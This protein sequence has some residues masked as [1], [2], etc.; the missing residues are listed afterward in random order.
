MIEV[1]KCIRPGDL[2][3]IENAKEAL[4]NK[5]FSHR[6][7][8]L[9]KVGRYKINQRLGLKTPNKLENHVLNIDDFV[10]IVR[11]V[12]RLNNT[13]DAVGD[14]ID[15]LCNRRLKLVGE[16]IQRSFRIGLLR[17]ERNIKERMLRLD[18]ETMM[19]QQ[20]IN[21]RPVVAAVKTFF[22][23]SQLSQYMDQV[24][25]LSELAHKRRL[26]AMGPG[27]LKREYAKFA[28]RDSH[29]THYG[30]IC[31]VETS[32]GANIGLILNLALYA[33]INEY[34]FL[35][36]PYCKVLSKGK[37]AEIV[38]EVA[39][40]NLLDN[41]GAVIVKA[42][43]AISK[44]SAERLAKVDAGQ[45]WQLQPR[46]LKDKVVYLDTKQE[47]EAIILG[48]SAQL[49]E[50]GR[51]IE[52]YEE[53][54]RRG[55]AG[56]YSVKRAA[57]MDF[58][59]KQIIGSSAGMIPFL[60]KDQVARSL[61]GANQTR[62][63]L[64]LI[65]PQAPIV[66]TGLEKHIARNSGQ[67]V[68]AEADGV[69]V[70]ATAD[71]VVVSYTTKRKHTYYPVHFARS[72]QDTSINQ[73]VVVDNGQKV[74]QGQPLI[75]GMS[76]EDGE[77]ALGS[78]VLVALMFWAGYNFEDAI[79]ISERLIKD[80][81]LTSINITEY[82]IDV[83]ETKLGPES[84]TLD[85]PNVAEDALRHLDEDGI[86]C[87]G[88][89]VKPGDILVG[90]ITP[91]GEQEL[92]NEERLL[93]AIFGEKAKD[94]RN[95]SLTLPNGKAGKVVDVRIFSK[96][97]GHDLRAGVLK[98]LQI[99]VAQSRKIQ[100]GD[101]LAGR[102][103]NKGVIARVLPVEDMPFTEDGQPVDLLFNPLGVP[104][105]MNLGQLFEAHLGIAAEK[106]GIKVT[107]PILEGVKEEKIV[108]MLKEAGLPEDGK[109]QLYD[110]RTGEP[111]NERTTIGPMYIYKLNHMVSD[112]V[113]V[114]S[115]GPYAMVTQQPLVGKSHNGGQRFGE[116]EVWALESYGAAN[117]L[118]EM[119]TLKSD[120]MSGRAKA[121]ESI[122]KQVD[123]VSPKIPESFNILVKELQ[124]L[125]L[126]IDLIDQDDQLVN[127]EEVLD[128]NL[129]Q[130]GQNQPT[131]VVPE[132]ETV[133]AKQVASDSSEADEEDDEEEN[134]N[135]DEIISSDINFDKEFDTNRGEAADKEAS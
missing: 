72:N 100:I 29:A 70:E 120:D 28:P 26:S 41:K 77:L 38:G 47:D 4:K 9:S 135:L 105:R 78:D 122:I 123:I 111:F 22:A 95:S 17:M 69:V 92:T 43:A 66:G 36:T 89:Q 42:G 39:G 16:L 58:S 98:Q 125:G 118:Q 1:Y 60:E 54:R 52:M 51:F 94:V 5:F 86:I 127:A 64:P 49:D 128:A 97:Q 129:H 20:L 61:V 131:I 32:E 82:S 46:V 106:L 90:K 37:A 44:A 15:D 101:K 74:K 55:I 2:A 91:K 103:G 104:A 14:D 134:D 21:S 62:Q 27:G 6:Q 114:R 85:I 50:H 3:N 18:I 119:L 96:E 93:R 115:T 63:A 33:R 84:T 71:K 109:Q 56:N 7:Y 102:H 34:G 132:E 113:H 88:A 65:Q 130:K 23:S 75:E 117:T 13:S 59:P 124:G 67:I 73:R 24:N 19:P 87:I 35:E 99:F 80:D 11:E 81:V 48:A 57:Y 83:R 112:K 30:R 25:P 8:D 68:Y 76:I 133:A 110:G 53:G 40:E 108:G 31:P 126:K 45:L 12:I 116:M 121:Y 10:A 79:I 107:T